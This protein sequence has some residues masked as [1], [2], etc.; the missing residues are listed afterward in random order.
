MKIRHHGLRFCTAAARLSLLSVSTLLFLSPSNAVAQELQAHSASRRVATARQQ[1][2]AGSRQ[3]TA[4]NSAQPAVAS[5]QQT[6]NPLTVARNTPPAASVPAPA[7]NVATTPPVARLVATVQTSVPP[8]TIAAARVSVSAPVTANAVA[9]ALTRYIVTDENSQL[10]Q[11]AFALIN[12]AR[13]ANGLQPLQWD[14]DAAQL[15]R[16]QSWQ[17]ATQGFFNHFDPAGRDV[18]G[19]AKELKI[20]DWRALGENIAYNRGFDQPADFAVERWL[21]S[22]GHKE[23][24]MRAGFTHAALGVSRTAEGR[25]YF[26]QVFIER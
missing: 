12:Q 20:R 24:I 7:R 14:A 19:R 3:Q 6:G 9:S 15:A 8:P 25:I 21:L 10:E 13:Q 26:T 11:R 4:T 18:A 1:P 16:A 5:Q 22:F 17:M 2:V 23:N